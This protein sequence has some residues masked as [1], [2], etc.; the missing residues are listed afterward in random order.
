M[1]KYETMHI[2]NVL[3]RIGRKY[4]FGYKQNSETYVSY[5]RNQGVK[6][7]NNIQIFS[8]YHTNID[9]L[10]PYLLTI[11]SNVVMTGPVTILTHDYSTTICSK[12]Y[13]NE[14]AVENAQ[15]TY[16]GNNVFL[17]WGCTVLAGSIIED[18]VIVGAH[19]VV[20]G[21]LLNNS[22]YVGV[23]AKRI[24]SLE[25]Y[26]KKRKGQQIEEA[27]NIYN[28]YYQWKGTEAPEKEYGSYCYLWRKKNGRMDNE[29]TVFKDFDEFC[30]YAKKRIK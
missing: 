15:A 25:E 27:F 4:I 28:M 2:S 13:Q 6:C 7:G 19:A 10:R 5:L 12:A 3:Q 26:Y 16:I 24:M 23:P 22:V 30:N 8:P 9:C 14:Q 1:S 17:G 18:N 20:S 21:R 11:G 29:D